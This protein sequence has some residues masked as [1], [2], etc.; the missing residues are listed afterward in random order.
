MISRPEPAVEANGR[1]LLIPRNCE[2]WPKI[3]LGKRGQL[4]L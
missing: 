2:R 1:R 3:L 4:P